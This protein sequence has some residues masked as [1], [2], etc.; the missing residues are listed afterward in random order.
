[1][2]EAACLLTPERRVK[3]RSAGTIRKSRDWELMRPERYADDD[4]GMMLLYA[5]NGWMKQ[6]GE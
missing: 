4:T 6:D 2:N 5:G 1:M 3:G